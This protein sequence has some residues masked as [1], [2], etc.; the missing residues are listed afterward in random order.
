MVRLVFLKDG[1]VGLLKGGVGKI[2]E[3]LDMLCKA[4]GSKDRRLCAA[5][6]NGMSAR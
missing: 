5:P 3:F 6:R 1:N 2:E 4:D